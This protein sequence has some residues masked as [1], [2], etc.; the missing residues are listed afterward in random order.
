ME[1]NI[2]EGLAWFALGVLLVVMLAAIAHAIER[3]MIPDSPSVAA[4][5]VIKNSPIPSGWYI[6]STRDNECFPMHGSD[7]VNV[8][9]NFMGVDPRDDDFNVLLNHY[10]SNGYTCIFSH[11]APGV[12]KQAAICETVQ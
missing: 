5:K 1:I 9:S 11:A 10:V 12:D 4:F 8:W 7:A 6:I 3:L 2:A